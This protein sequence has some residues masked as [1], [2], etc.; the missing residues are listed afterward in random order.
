MSTVKQIN[1]KRLGRLSFVYLCILAGFAILLSRAFYFQ[2]IKGRKYAELARRQY[3]R[4]ITLIPAR[5]MILDRDGRI[6]AQSVLVDSFYADPLVIKNKSKTALVVG[7]LLNMDPEEILKKITSDKQ[8]VWIKRLVDPETAKKLLQYHLK[9][10]YS[11]KEYRRFYPNSNLAS[12]VLGFAGID[13]KGL[14]GLELAF[15]SYLRGTPFLRL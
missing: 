8:F 3:S 4:E 15:D 11:L 2:I 6:L 12:N 10:I 9:G 1:E 7:R 5:G 13:S 14:S